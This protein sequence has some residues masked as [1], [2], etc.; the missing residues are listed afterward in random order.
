[1]LVTDV[2]AR[3]KLRVG[4]C[5]VSEDAGVFLLLDEE[6]DQVVHESS[7]AVTARAHSE[8]KHYMEV[9]ESAGARKQVI[10]QFVVGGSLH[11]L[12]QC[13]SRS[14]RFSVG[15]LRVV[16]LWGQAGGMIVF[17]FL[18]FFLR[19]HLSSN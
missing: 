10:D 11:L 17:C 13:C 5:L 15:V 14:G 16:F 3:A 9:A 1:M 18:L 2:F 6:R 8:V 7:N 4:V 12:C 19:H